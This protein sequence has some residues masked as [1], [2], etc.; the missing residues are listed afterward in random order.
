MGTPDPHEPLPCILD[1]RRSTSLYCLG[2]NISAPPL[3]CRGEV[4]T[5]PRDQ[6]LAYLPQENDLVP[7]APSLL[8]VQ[9]QLLQLLPVI[10]APKPLVFNSGDIEQTQ[11][12]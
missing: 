9:L 6:P 12:C 2:D 4:Y 11:D 1:F 10:E 7:L 5:I 3:T 8:G